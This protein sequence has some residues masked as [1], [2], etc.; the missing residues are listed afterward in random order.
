MVFETM[1]RPGT[2]GTDFPL[3]VF[4]RGR[5][6]CW[7]LEVHDTHA[8]FGPPATESTAQRIAI[9]FGLS[10]KEFVNEA[11]FF[12]RD[13]VCRSAGSG[14]HGCRFGL[15]R[16]PPQPCQLRLCSHLCR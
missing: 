10:S 8:G 13:D 14:F 12:V 9:R 1:L 4:L 15:G 16:R 6:G 3:P 7:S 5:I 2:A 11:L